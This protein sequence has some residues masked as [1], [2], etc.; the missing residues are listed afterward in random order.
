[1]IDLLRE[2]QAHDCHEGDLDGVGVS[3]EREDEGGDAAAGAVG[4]ET[5]AFV[6]KPLW[7]KQKRLRRR[8]GDP[9]RVPSIF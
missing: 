6:L 7:K 8:A 4:R 2:Q 3:Q 9:H 1:M 5:D